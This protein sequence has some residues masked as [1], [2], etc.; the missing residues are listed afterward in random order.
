MTEE[1]A[2]SVIC[3]KPLVYVAG[4]YSHPDPV[5]NTHNAV[6]FAET[7]LRDGLVT[8]VVPH[9]TML[10]HA[11]FPH[12]VE[13]WYAYDLEILARCD[14][15]FRLPGDSTGADKE[16]AYANELGLPVF[17]HVG[18]LNLWAQSRKL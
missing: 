1:A 4:P 15:L 17:D 5:A 13:T 12:D 16:V 11:I 7:R 2:K 9:L 10:W 18:A 6:E 14:A 3:S 8:P